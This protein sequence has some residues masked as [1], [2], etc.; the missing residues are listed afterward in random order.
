MQHTENKRQ[1]VKH[2][3]QAWVIC[4][5]VTKHPWFA[6]GYQLP[7]TWLQQV[8]RAGQQQEHIEVHV[9]ST[10]MEQRHAGCTNSCMTSANPCTCSNGSIKAQVAAK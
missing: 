3:V 4:N 7:I 8:D 2:T 9:A 6:L 5:Q 1:R 10:S